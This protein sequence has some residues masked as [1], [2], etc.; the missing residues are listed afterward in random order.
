MFEEYFFF[1]YFQGK[2]GL[3]SAKSEFLGGFSFFEVWFV[4]F[5]M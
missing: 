4:D 1:F 5:C 2:T 3:Q